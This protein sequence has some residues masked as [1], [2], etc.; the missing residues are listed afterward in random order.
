MNKI[1]IRPYAANLWQ[2]AIMQH[3]YK[4]EFYITTNG[5]NPQFY[6]KWIDHKKAAKNVADKKIPAF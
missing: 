5:I 4:T 6:P 2:K 1:C 3:R